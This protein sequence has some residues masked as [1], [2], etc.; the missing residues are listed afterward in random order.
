MHWELTTSQPLGHIIGL[1]HNYQHFLYWKLRHRE[2]KDLAQDYQ[3]RENLHR[4]WGAPARGSTRP[5]TG[6]TTSVFIPSGCV[7]AWWVIVCLLYFP[8]AFIFSITLLPAA[9]FISLG[10]NH[11]GKNPAMSR[12]F[13]IWAQTSIIAGPCAATCCPPQP[14]EAV[15]SGLPCTPVHLGPAE[16]RSP[17]G[18]VLWSPLSL[19]GLPL[20]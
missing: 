13:L 12:I 7:E 15:S 16:T 3:L 8:I 10:T 17:V 4:A 14:R 20:E 2:V 9:L 6:P 1:F 11:K 19:M 18:L 5:T